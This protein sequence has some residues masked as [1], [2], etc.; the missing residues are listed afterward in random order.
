YVVCEHRQIKERGVKYKLKS[1]T[2]YPGAGSYEKYLQTLDH[3]DDIKSEMRK[4]SRSIINNATSRTKELIA[5]QDQMR[6][7]YEARFDKMT[8]V[9]SNGF[10]SVESAITSFHAS[11]SENM[12]LALGRLD[13]INKK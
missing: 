3:I 11:F 12:E 5:N 4:A 1:M 7:M 9:L 10:S 6:E 2:W 8:N 13:L